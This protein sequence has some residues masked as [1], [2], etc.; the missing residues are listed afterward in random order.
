MPKNRGRGKPLPYGGIKKAFQICVG[1]ALGPPAKIRHRERWLGKARRGSGTASA[2]IFRKARAQWPGG[3][4]D[5]PLRFCA[6]ELFCL[7][8]GVTPVNGGPGVSGPMGTKCPSA[9]SPGDPLGTFPS[10]GKY[11]A[12]QGET[13]QH[14]AAK[15]PAQIKTNFNPLPPNPFTPM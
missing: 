14:R 4:L 3:D 15:S 8:Q 9:A 2:I 13:L 7:A 10:L 5:Q 12:P 11:L 1:E 6:P